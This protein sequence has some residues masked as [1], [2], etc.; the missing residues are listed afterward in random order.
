MS[1]MLSVAV[2]VCLGVSSTIP[3]ELIVSV[4]VL[5]TVTF[6]DVVTVSSAVAFILSI[7]LLVVRLVV[8]ATFSVKL[9]TSTE[10]SPVV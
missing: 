9:S 7:F 8:P 4:V 1:V 3:S 6:L 10:V 2:V 5:A